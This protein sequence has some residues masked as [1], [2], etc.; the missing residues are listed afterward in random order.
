MDVVQSVDVPEGRIRADRIDIELDAVH[1][2]TLL[3]NRDVPHR[4]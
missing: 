4:L 3:G 1:P 2:A